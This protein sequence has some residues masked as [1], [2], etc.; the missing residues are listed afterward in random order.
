MKKFTLGLVLTVFMSACGGGGG[1]IIP[2]PATTPIVVSI[3][4]ATQTTIDQ[5]QTVDF[6]ASL[7][8]DTTSAGVKWSASGAGCTGNACGTFTNVTTTAARYNAPAPVTNSSNVTVTATAVADSTK[9]SASTVVVKPAPHINTLSLPEVQRHFT[10]QRRRG[11]PHLE[12]GQRFL[13]G[14]FAA[15]QR[16]DNFRNPHQHKYC[17][18]DFKLHSAGDGS[19]SGGVRAIFRSPSIQHY[20]YGGLDDHYD[21]GRLADWHG[22]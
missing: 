4:P 21:D 7:T 16:G 14:R 18:H 2:P 6:S 1:G 22:G 19:V 12:P 11:G 20:G 15:K 13:A 10:G 8:H 3:S 9:S 5:G 17:G